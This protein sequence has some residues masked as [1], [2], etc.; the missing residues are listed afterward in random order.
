VF[1]STSAGTPVEVINW[2]EKSTPAKI[3][4]DWSVLG[5]SGKHKVRDL[6][7]QKDLGEF[8]DGFEAEVPYHG[9]VL[10]KIFK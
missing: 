2:G 6:W 4:V 8:S 7:R 5:I 3:K 9:V 10:V 1:F